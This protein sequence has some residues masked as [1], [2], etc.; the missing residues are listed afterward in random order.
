MQKLILTIEGKEVCLN[1][2]P[3]W[4]FELYKQDSG[5]DLVKDPYMVD[6]DID[7]VE[8][9]N[10]LQSMVWAAYQANCKVERIPVDLKREDVEYFVMSGVTPIHDLAYSVTAAYYGVTVDELKQKA[11][12]GKDEKK[13]Q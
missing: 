2:A 7:S 9:F 6:I 12:E 4:F 11:S 13:N 10:Y 8:L 3:N 5:H 1:F